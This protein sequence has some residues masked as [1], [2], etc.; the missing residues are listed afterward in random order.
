MKKTTLIIMIFMSYFGF[1]QN[2]TTGVV[3]FTSNFS[4]QFDVNASTD[5][6]TMT[7]VGPSNVWL[8]VA[9]NISS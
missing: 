2:T 6:V 4:V 3:Q 1:A 5:I 8:G 9:L 7:M